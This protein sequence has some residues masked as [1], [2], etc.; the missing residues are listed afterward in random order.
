MYNI[1]DD[2]SI[3]FFDEFDQLLNV[4]DSYG[5]PLTYFISA[6]FL[7]FFNNSYQY[8][9]LSNQ[10]FNIV[11]IISIFH[12]GKL[13][14]NQSTG[15]WASLIFRFSSLIINQR[16]D[17]LIDLSLTSFSNL[18]F[19]FFTKWYLDNNKFSYYSS[20]SGIS[21]G[22]IFLTRPT[23]IINFIFPFTLI[24]LKLIKRKYSFTYILA[25]LIF[26][27]AGFIVLIFP[28]FSRNWLTIITSTINAWEWGINYQEGLESNSLESWI[29]Y[30][31]KLPLMFGPI[32]FSIFSIILLVETVFHNNLSRLKFRSITKINLYFLLFLLNCYL[33]ISLMSTKDIRFF[34]PI[35]PISCIYLGL[36]LDAKNFKFFTSSNKKITI[37]ISIIISLLFTKNGLISKYFI[38]YSKY[39]WP[40]YEIVNE[41][42]KENK[43]LI[44]T[45]AVLPDTKEINTFNLEA[46]ASMQGEYVA[47]RQVISNKE[48]YKDDLEYF[49][50]FLLKTGDQGVMSNEAKD[51]LNKYLLNS[52]SFIIQ[53][54][55]N[56]L[57]KSK[58]ILLK[59]KSLN[60]YLSRKDCKYNNSN[61]KIKK[62]PEGL[63]LNIVRKGEFLKSSNILIDFIGE[64]FKTS[65]NF[66]L[67]NGSFH[68]NFDESSCFSL[69]QEIPIT[70]PNK[71]PQELNIKA[72]ILDKNDE[73]KLLNLEVKKLIIKGKSDDENYIKMAN[74]IS[75]VSLLGDYL[76]KGEFKKLFN[77]V[78]IINQS[79][80]KQ[81]YL[82]D[83]EK[84]F[85]QR[86]LE[87]KNLKNLYN[88]LICQILQRHVASA[89][90]TINQILD[91]DYS[92]GNAQLTKAIINIYLLDK[93]DAKIALNNLIFYRMVL[94]IL[95]NFD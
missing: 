37:V 48:T 45:L 88:V 63:K 23:G 67:A 70:F 78:G 54:E 87:D 3:N 59:R 19:L 82:K 10:I 86:Y 9:Y 74:K 21:L 93:K 6:L 11:S 28:W 95:S 16:S 52:P 41:I 69:T 44:S 68:R 46:E 30:F 62:I 15:I 34:M 50:W 60:T 49:D 35:F 53:K 51:L 33:I 72:K 26:F 27:F 24:I 84:I 57:D 42:K 25:E 4:T 40:H 12:L 39:N 92:N 89:E 14:K 17:Y 31:K 29:F 91:S 77:L 2:Q 85:Y 71:T 18:G 65:T 58:L 56:L 38:G 76:R 64:D 66:S 75:K 7:K 94:L 73:T 80:P 13:L 90:K 5:G 61:L 47:V 83:S 36:F 22:L 8:A 1:S 81:I 20:L 43:N 55:W 32:N 79:D